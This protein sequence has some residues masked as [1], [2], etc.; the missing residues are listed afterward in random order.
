M[1]A[2]LVLREMLSSASTDFVSTGFGASYSNT[3]IVGLYGAAPAGSAQGLA[4]AMVDT[5]KGLDVSG[6]LGAAKA[7]A[8][9]ASAISFES[10]HDVLLEVSE[11]H[12][13]PSHSAAIDAVTAADVQKLLKG[14]PTVAALGDTT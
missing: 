2:S 3:G 14:A 13:E 6:A 12:A 11:T 1:G 10:T 7:R 9:V 5:L 8:K 4:G